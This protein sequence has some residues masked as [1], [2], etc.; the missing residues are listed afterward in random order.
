MYPC[1]GYGCDRQIRRLIVADTVTNSINICRRRR[2]RPALLA[3]CD[4]NVNL[5]LV[6]SIMPENGLCGL[7]RPGRRLLNLIPINTPADLVNRQLIATWL[8]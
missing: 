3:D 8:N 4:L 1:V 5:K 7:P 2:V 6:D